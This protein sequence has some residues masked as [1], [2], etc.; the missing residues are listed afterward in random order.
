MS[1]D[2]ASSINDP[3]TEREHPEAVAQTSVP[4]PGSPTHPPAAVVHPAAAIPQPPSPRPATASRLPFDPWRLVKAAGRRWHWLALGALAFAS[5]AGGIGLARGNYSLQL[6]LTLRDLATRFSATGRDAESYRPP[7]LAGATMVGLLTSPELLD[8]VSSHADPPLTARDLQSSLTITQDKGSETVRVAFT[9]KK[10]GELVALANQYAAAAVEKSRATQKED[11]GGVLTNFDRKLAELGREK[12]GLTAQLSA[13]RAESGMVD[14]AVENPALEKEWIDLRVKIDIARGELALLDS[15]QSLLITEPMRQD[16]QEAGEHLRVLL[17]QG[18]LDAHPD[19]R[20]VREQISQLTQQL[21]EIS[22]NNDAPATP[23]GLYAAQLTLAAARKKAAEAEVLQFENQAAAL[24][25][26]LDQIYAHTGE[27]NRLKSELDRLENYEQTLNHRKF[28]AQQYYDNAEGYFRPQSDALTLADVDARA[29]SAQITAWAASGGFV[30]LFAALG[31]VLL[32][33]LGDSRLKTVADVQRVTRLPVLAG[34]GDLNRLDAEARRAWAFR[35]WTIL[36]GTL[37]QSPHSG[38]V[39][40]FISAAHGEGRSSWVNLLAEAAR[41]RGHEVTQVDC[42]EA[43]QAS[44]ASNATPNPGRPLQPVPT[45]QGTGAD[46]VPR[47][48]PAALAQIQL[49]GLVWNLERRLQFQREL[50]KWRAVSRAVILIDLPPASV[51]EAILLAEGLPQLIWLA[52]AGKSRAQETRLHLE[53]LHHAR[54]NMIG[55]VLN[56]QP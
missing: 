13:L 16:L 47:S 11:P 43:G 53:T 12:S 23:G 3:Q 27:H 22:T 46:L 24:K 36:S 20:R 1:N 6:T 33:E 15:R 34:L 55:A 39:C 51:P 17:A 32:V 9:G 4:L 56:H 54:C 50:D 40:G 37:A 21:A 10:P 8:F 41:E 38:I 18:K 52:D 5:A 31:L 30:G 44:P 28:E 35:T 25:A 2:E 26:R 7:Q 14:P 29:R 45:A 48:N 19:V 49:P 42:A